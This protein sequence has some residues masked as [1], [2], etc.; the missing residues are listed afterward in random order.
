MAA[1]DAPVSGSQARLGG[2]NS[3]C[4]TTLCVAFREVDKGVW[5]G[6]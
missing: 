6:L 4:A 5:G 3:E 2:S 1:F